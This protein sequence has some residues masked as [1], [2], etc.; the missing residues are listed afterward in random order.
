MER[1]LIDMLNEQDKQK[2]EAQADAVL[3]ETGCLF[4]TPVKVIS[5]ARR[6]GFFVGKAKLKE[7]ME[8]IIAVDKTKEDL[9]GTG[10]NMVI[11]IDRNLDI[12]R[13]RFIVAHELGHYFLRD[14]KDEP[15][16]AMRETTHGRTDKENEADYFA[17]C[18]LMPRQAYLNALK[19]ACQVLGLPDD[20]Q[21][22]Q[23]EKA[24]DKVADFL[25]KQFNVPQLA[26]LRR[27]DEVSKQ[28]EPQC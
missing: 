3:K 15:V 8:G 21:L 12:A 9:F 14:K 19:S 23:N 28:N 6:L 13:L 5:I 1:W 22:N 4:E 26:A 24:K 27:M 10:Q 17:A 18:I 16:F 20:K 25:S 11:A 2:I 7:G